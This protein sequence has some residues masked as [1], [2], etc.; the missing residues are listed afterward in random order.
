MIEN[1]QRVLLVDD[2]PIIL[3][4][5]KDEIESMNFTCDTTSDV[6]EALQ[7]LDKSMYQIVITDM[8]MPKGGGARVVESCKQINH[9]KVYLIT[10]NLEYS[11]SEL[12]EMGFSGVFRKP[13]D[14]NELNRVLSGDI[15]EL[16][17]H[18]DS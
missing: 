3:S 16:S 17:A 9:T 8:R 6:D 10:G 11:E 2:E 4:F 5:L 7:L 14:F 15:L 18:T 13:F 12:K 1:S